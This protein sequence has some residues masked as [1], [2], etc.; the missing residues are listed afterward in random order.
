LEQEL[1]MVRA[2]L[3]EPMARLYGIHPDDLNVP[4]ASGVQ[5]SQSQSLFD[6]FKDLAGRC[7]WDTDQEHAGGLFR[8][9]ALQA[10]WDGVSRNP[11]AGGPAPDGPQPHQ[12]AGWSGGGPVRPYC[13]NCGRLR[14][15]PLHIAG[16]LVAPA[17]ITHAQALAA[18]DEA[19]DEIKDVQVKLAIREAFTDAL[20]ASPSDSATTQPAADIERMVAVLREAREALITCKTGGYR[21]IDGDWCERRWF[22]DKLTSA[23]ISAIDAVL[24]KGAT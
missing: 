10:L 21:D 9:K 16:V 15:D 13:A 18:L 3:R 2:A 5:P 4:D 6:S 23:A 14:D 12:F 8:D 17:T 7:G 19:C 20:G 1:F 22:D 24:P 11:A